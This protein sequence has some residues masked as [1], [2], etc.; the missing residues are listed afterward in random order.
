MAAGFTQS[1]QNRYAGPIS[2]RRF[3]EPQREGQGGGARRGRALAAGRRARVAGRGANQAR[4][5]HPG[6]DRGRAGALARAGALHVGQ[7]VRLGLGA[8]G[9]GH[10]P[11]S[12]PAEPG[13]PLH[14]PAAR[15]RPHQAFITGAA[16]HTM[17]KP[18]QLTAMISSTALDL[19]E[20]REQVRDACLHE[21]VFPIGMEQL[22]A[23]DASGIRVSLEMVD[24]ADIYIGVYAWRYGWVPDFDNP[25]KISIT[26]MEFN[27]ALERK[28]RGELKEILIF[29]MHDEH[30]IR[31]CDKE[32]G[33]EAQRKLKKFKKRASA[34]RV[35][36]KFKS[37][38]ELRGQVIQS[39]ADLKRRFG[40]SDGQK[41]KKDETIPKPPAFYAEPD[42][43]GSQKFV[44]RESQLL[45]LNDWA[46]A[47]DPT[48][49]LLFDA[50]GGNGKSALTWEWTNNHAIKVRTDWAGRFWYSFYER[51]AV[52]ADFCR[53]ALSYMTGRPLEELDKMRTPE[54]AKDLL[55]QLHSQPWL[56]ILDGLEP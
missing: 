54:L 21:G 42:Y 50:I 29:V 5:Q 49:L 10:V 40:G 44:G 34:G 8:V 14:S 12:R 28:Q 19:P 2:I 26:E 17:N 25:G 22:P 30:S 1:N 4:R 7:C 15:R 46:K 43:I 37:K 33:N 36:L 27:H 16:S 45:D 6:E 3:L 9:G 32:D 53:R 23:R 11:V 35:M 31:A 55:A 48:N 39:L 56:L 38:E 18:G 13:A 41:D 52:M 51:G 47:A 24:Q 20:H